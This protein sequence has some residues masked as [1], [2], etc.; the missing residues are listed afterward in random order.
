[1]FRAKNVDR[2]IL[3]NLKAMRNSCLRREP[4]FQGFQS[5][6]HAYVILAFA[7]FTLATSVSSTTIRNYSRDTSITVGVVAHQSGCFRIKRSFRRRTSIN[8]ILQSHTKASWDQNTALA[9]YPSAYIS[10]ISTHTTDFEPATSE[11]N[12]PQTN[13]EA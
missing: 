7:A 1:M 4:N 12:S 5:K 11:T 13:S 10:S 8:R 9:F 3:M 2:G 6:L